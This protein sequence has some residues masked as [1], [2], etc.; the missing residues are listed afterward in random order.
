[1]IFFLFKLL[2]FLIKE[3]NTNNIEIDSITEDETKI[4]NADMKE[5]EKKKSNKWIIIILIILGLIALLLWCLNSSEPPVKEEAKTEKIQA[6]PTP[7]NEISEDEVMDEN[8]FSNREIIDETAENASIN[9]NQEN[10][11]SDSTTPNPNRNP[12]FPNEYMFDKKFDFKLV[13]FMQANFPNMK[14]I[15]YGTPREVELKEGKRLTLMSLEYYGDKHFWVYIYLYNTDIIKN[16]DLIPA[17][18]ILKVPRLDK[19]L[20]DPNNQANI[21]AA[22]DVQKYLLKM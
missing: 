9:E 22:W 7:E 19:S 15:T 20:V 2:C 11:D 1:M 12:E 14:L 10:A 13:D 16:P 8:Q 21:D 6:T 18:T 5:K 17:G 3:K 4:K